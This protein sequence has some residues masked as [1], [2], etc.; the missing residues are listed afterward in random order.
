M[1]AF[2]DCHCGCWTDIEHVIL[3]WNARH[4]QLLETCVLIFMIQAISKFYDLVDV[5]VF[6]QS[7]YALID[8]W[9]QGLIMHDSSLFSKHS[10]WL[11]SWKYEETCTKSWWGERG[12]CGTGEMSFQNFFFRTQVKSNLHINDPSPV[13]ELRVGRNFYKM[14]PCYINKA[15]PLRYILI[16]KNSFSVISSYSILV[17]SKI[18][19]FPK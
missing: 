8:L 18:R 6:F 9:S 5:W 15:C 4:W 2:C 11:F 16:C 1:C 7:M 13:D 10:G 12:K 3:L 17:L 14:F 19:I